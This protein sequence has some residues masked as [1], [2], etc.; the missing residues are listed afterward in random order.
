MRKI[1]RFCR[2]RYLTVKFPLKSTLRLQTKKHSP[3][4]FG[5]CFL[6]NQSKPII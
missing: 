1:F 4:T 3:E 6:E 2:K 5:K